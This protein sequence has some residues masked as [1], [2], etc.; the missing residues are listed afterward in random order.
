[1]QGAISKSHI[2]SRLLSLG[3][4]PND[5]KERILL[6]YVCAR[7]AYQIN[8]QEPSPTVIQKLAMNYFSLK[9]YHSALRLA[10]HWFSVGQKEPDS[11]A[12]ALMFFI[13]GVS[14]F[15]LKKYD[16][17]AETLRRAISGFVSSKDND[18]LMEARRILEEELPRA[19]ENPQVI[20]VVFK[21]ILTLFR[22]K[23]KQRKDRR[24]RMSKHFLREMNYLMFQEKEF[25][26]YLESGS[27]NGK[28]I[29]TIM[30]LSAMG[31]QEKISWKRKEKRSNIWDQ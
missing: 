20:L 8:S 16:Q 3:S 2:I 13:K 21:L 1:M 26:F 5:E 9:N 22:I 18:K 12:R 10:E 7:Q 4:T 6:S 23:L 25:I 30:K 31:K 28:I 14:L 19:R 29:I 15:H 11:N 24:L 27:I 17:V